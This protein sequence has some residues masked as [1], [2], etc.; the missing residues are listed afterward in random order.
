M[1]R[2]VRILIVEDEFITLDLIQVYLVE[3]GYEI[4]GDAMNAEEAIEV[5]AHYDTD[6]VI[7]DINIQGDKDGIWIAEQIRS[8]YRIPFIF[9]TAYSDSETVKRAAGVNP[10]GY[11]VKPF[12]QADI[13]TSIEVAL[14]N[15]EKEHERLDFPQALLEGEGEVGDSVFVKVNSTYEKLLISEIQY[16]QSYKNYIEV[17]MTNKRILVRSSLQQFLSILPQK[18][19]MQI[20]RSFV[21]N[22]NYIDSV[23]NEFILIG[24]SKIPFSK[25]YKEELFKRIRLL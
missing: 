22:I 19:F 2:K 4:S 24:D 1:E 9:L 14:K 13:F 7:L 15:Y 8:D 6:L 12:T 17:S 3:A 21:V 10:Y 23:E 5:L 16:A 20:H 25:S 18:N 11:L